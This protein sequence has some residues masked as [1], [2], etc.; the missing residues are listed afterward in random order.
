MISKCVAVNLRVRTLWDERD[1]KIPDW[2]CQDGSGCENEC[3]SE[4][5][6]VEDGVKGGDDLVIA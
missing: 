4:G 3:E 2:A 6:Y 1:C 5:F